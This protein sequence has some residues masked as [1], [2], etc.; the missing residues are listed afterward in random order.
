MTARPRRIEVIIDELVLHGFDTRDGPGIAEATA[1]GLAEALAGWSP[2]AGSSTD[3][4]AAG[5]FTVP[6]AAPPPVVGQGAAHRIGQALHQAAH[7]AVPQT[8]PQTVPQAAHP[9]T[10]PPPGGRD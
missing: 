4:L 6:A 5:S 3:R 1:T 10:P 8:V 7:P 2:P 9:A